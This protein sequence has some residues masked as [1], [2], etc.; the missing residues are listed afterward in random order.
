MYIYKGH[1]IHFKMT[2][3]ASIEIARLCPD[4]DI[5]RVSEIFDQNHFAKT[6]ENTAKF[7][8]ALHRGAR[9]AEDGR[10]AELYLTEDDIY[11]M[12]VSEV[13][14]LQL[15]AVAAFRRDGKTEVEIKPAKNGEGEREIEAV[16]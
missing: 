6:M 10:D 2:V 4:G 8:V 11:N 9:R 5:S 16:D 14:E 7:I 15:A 13:Q 12:D 3:G 1:E